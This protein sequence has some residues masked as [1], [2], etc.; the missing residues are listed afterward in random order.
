MFGPPI[1]KS[2][3]SLALL[4]VLFAPVVVGERPWPTQK[5][6]GVVN[7][8]GNTS[9]KADTEI[10]ASDFASSVVPSSMVEMAAESAPPPEGYSAETFGEVAP[11]PDAP[12]AIDARH[13][14]N[15]KVIMYPRTHWQTRPHGPIN[16]VINRLQSFKEHLDGAEEQA[17]SQADTYAETLRE[18][19]KGINVYRTGPQTLADSVQ[20]HQTHKLAMVQQAIKEGGKRG[21]VEDL[22]E[23]DDGGAEEAPTAALGDDEDLDTSNSATK[24]GTATRKEPPKKSQVQGSQD[25]DDLG[26][27]NDE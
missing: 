13:E 21:D 10:E 26:G 20:R 22:L 12:P 23:A 27:S 24:S 9:S 1:C 16:K 8:F 3:V 14:D 17:R 7:P 2:F 5:G 11:G 15:T 25:E 19:G 18:L 6:N 4:A